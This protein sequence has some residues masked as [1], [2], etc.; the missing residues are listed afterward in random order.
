M[1]KDKSKN[2]KFHLCSTIKPC[3]SFVASC[4]GGCTVSTQALKNIIN[5]VLSYRPVL[6]FYQ[7]P[8][9]Q[10]AQNFLL[11]QKESIKRN[12]RGLL[13]ALQQP[14]YQHFQGAYRNF[15]VS[16]SL[17][18]QKKSYQYLQALLKKLTMNC[19]MQQKNN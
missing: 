3:A 5:H 4:A 1:S 10:T 18:L 9:G 15:L 7:A 16:I 11:M 14:E 2:T 6:T 8:S 17:I 19:S 12:A 13:H